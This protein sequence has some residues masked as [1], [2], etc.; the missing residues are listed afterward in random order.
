M[1]GV[2]VFEAIE[3]EGRSMLN[4]EVTTSKIVIISES[5]AADLEKG[6]VFCTSKGSKVLIPS[7]GF[8]PSGL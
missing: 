2:T 7:A 3:V 4:L 6:A 1:F 8:C 5:L